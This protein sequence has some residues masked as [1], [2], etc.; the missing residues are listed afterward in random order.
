MNFR[1]SGTSAMLNDSGKLRYIDIV[2][3]IIMCVEMMRQY[4][5]KTMSLYMSERKE[6]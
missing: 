1:Q 4:I 5:Y 6:L 3:G 2:V